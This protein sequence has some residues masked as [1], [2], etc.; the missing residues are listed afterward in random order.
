VRS[1]G[2]DYETEAR[3]YHRAGGFLALKD[4][5]ENLLRTY[6]S[7][8][9]YINLDEWVN[10][11]GTACHEC[12]EHYSDEDLVWAEDVEGSLCESCRSFCQRCERYVVYRHYDAEREAG[13]YCVEDY[14]LECAACGEKSWEDDLKN[15]EVPWFDQPGAALL[16]DDCLAESE[17]AEE[18]REDLDDGATLPG[19]IEIALASA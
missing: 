13:E 4:L 10:G 8:S 6:N 7:R 11:V 2:A 1:A 18:L 5:I 3:T 17:E 19:Q 9:P 16:C 15:I 12:G 14:M